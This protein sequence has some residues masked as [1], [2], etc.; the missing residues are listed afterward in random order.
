MTLSP[1]Q[2]N[3]GR[4]LAVIAACCLGVC[5][6]QLLLAG[7]T[8]EVRGHD[9]PRRVLIRLNDRN[10]VL[11]VRAGADSPA[12]DRRVRLRSIRERSRQIQRSLIRDLKVM[13]IA[14]S[15]DRYEVRSF[16]I[17]NGL[18]AT[19]DEAQI[20]E[21]SRRGDVAEIIDLKRLPP[22]VARPGLRPGK[23]APVTWGLSALSIPQVRDMYGLTGAGVVIGHLDTGVDA[24]HPDL[25]GKILRF[26]DFTGKNGAEPV[27]E[28]GHGTHTAAT[29]VGGSSSG[30]GIGIAP[31]AMLISA[32]VFNEDGADPEQILAAMEWIVDPDGDPE[33]DDA[34][35]IISNSWGSDDSED[36][37]FWDA[38]RTWIDLGIFPL[39]ATGNTSGLAGV[40]AAYPF[41]FSVGAVTRKNERAPFSGFGP[42]EW[43]GVSY[44]KPSIVAP[45]VDILSAW[46]TGNGYRSLEGTSMACP[47]V[48]GVVALMLQGNPD[49]DAATMQSALT[50]TAIDLGR[51]GVDHRFGHGMI[52]PVNAVGRIMGS[53]RI[54]GRVMDETGT[55]LASTIRVPRFSL[56]VPTRP[57]GT[58]EIYLPTGRHTIWALAAGHGTVSSRI[59]TGDP[60]TTNT[61]DF[62]LPGDTK[63][64]FLGRVTTE[65]AEPLAARV[66]VAGNDLEIFV[67]TD[68]ST[69]EFDMTLSEG[70]HTLRFTSLGHQHAFVDDL[71]VKP[72]GMRKLNVQL[73]VR[74]DLLL[75]D[76][77]RSD[78]LETYYQ[79]SLG[80]LGRAT[81]VWDTRLRG[82]IPESILMDYPMV[83]WQT[84]FDYQTALTD[85]E[86]ARVERYLRSGGRLYLAGQVAGV[87]L[88]RTPYYERVLHAK[89][90][91][92]L[93]RKSLPELPPL[94]GVM[95]DP[96]GDGLEFSLNGRG[97]QDNQDFPT[98]VGAGSDEAQVF[99][100]FSPEIGP[101]AIRVQTNRTRFVYTG[102]GLE[103]VGPSETRDLLLGRIL[104]WLTP[105]STE[106]VDRT[107]LMAEVLSEIGAVVSLERLDNQLDQVA[108]A[109]L[110]HGD[111]WNVLERLA[112]SV[113]VGP[114]MPTDVSGISLARGLKRRLQMSL[115]ENLQ[116]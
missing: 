39:F 57:D 62:S 9:Q 59:R 101:A 40:P 83:I 28:E 33:T 41:S 100:N 77:D 86:Q 108:A 67:D 94:L 49:L 112:V 44:I 52:N 58:Y 35:R 8:V 111:A 71:F 55:G 26:R 66:T 92:L 69:G 89:W 68:P 4:L 24:T 91:G 30:I 102:F 22:L 18:A 38:T 90:K 78:L 23:R 50:E 34:P 106:R 3:V 32:R 27:D 15:A 64:T 16:W 43:D 95:G 42:I 45:G 88:Q 97:T 12:L 65:N 70:S 29:L 51:E 21:V 114:G 2:L 81:A 85:D 54:V 109:V 10:R 84:G 104:D 98:M 73:R 7:D 5:H 79:S 72:S 53:P 99:L 80:R 82:T 63:I 61:F 110:D 13:N 74:P 46:P 47:H 115:L 93:K 1:W 107:R 56:D 75:V 19:L 60:G 11:D 96:I 14:A 31:D 6:A 37:T 87:L 17:T 20:R 48:S 76:D 113:P 36:R 116:P 103:G 105:S 25:K